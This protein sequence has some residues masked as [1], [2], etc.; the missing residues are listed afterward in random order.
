MERVDSWSAITFTESASDDFSSILD[1]S[2]LF[3]GCLLQFLS[4][5]FV[6]IWRLRLR[7]DCDLRGGDERSFLGCW[8]VDAESLLA[9]DFPLRVSSLCAFFLF[10]LGKG[11]VVTAASPF[12]SLASKSERK[13]VN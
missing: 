2:S 8:D 13:F 3:S 12:D 10:L 6:L 9:S 1:L 11:V 5:E 4:R 7:G